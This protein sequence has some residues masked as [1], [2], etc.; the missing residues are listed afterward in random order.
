M[1]RRGFSLIEMLVAM[2]VGSVV[3]GIAVGM[4]HA[5]LH[6]PSRPA[7]IARPGHEF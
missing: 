4:L 5:L 7:A 1:L 3:V 2:T 6:R